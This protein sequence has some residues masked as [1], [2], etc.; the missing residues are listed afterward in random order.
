MFFFLIVFTV[1]GVTAVRS[2]KGVMWSIPYRVYP[3]GLKVWYNIDKRWT[4]NGKEFLGKGI[5][6]QILKFVWNHLY[7][8]HSFSR[9]V[10]FLYSSFSQMWSVLD[11]GFDVKSDISDTILFCYLSLLWHNSTSVWKMNIFGIGFVL[12]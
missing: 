7:Y 2:D 3:K 6:S 12:L 11:N 9:C 4:L 1:S 5:I 10:Y 8:H